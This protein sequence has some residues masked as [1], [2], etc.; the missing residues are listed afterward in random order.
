MRSN[1]GLQIDNPSRAATPN[2]TTVRQRRP[3]VDLLNI[4]LEDLGR[5]VRDDAEDP[6]VSHVMRYGQ[7]LMELGLGSKQKPKN[8]RMIYHATLLMDWAAQ[9]GYTLTHALERMIG[10]AHSETWL[11]GSGHSE[12]YSLE[13]A[14]ELYENVLLDLDQAADPSVWLEYSQVLLFQGNYDLGSRTT[15]LIATKFADSPN[16]PIYLLNAAAMYFAAGSFDQA[17]KNLFQSIQQGPPKFFTKSEMLFMLSRTFEQS[18]TLDDSRAEDGYFMVFQNLDTV[19][20]GGDLT[21]EE[22]LNSASTWTQIADKCVMYG[23]YSLASDLYGQALV[24]DVSAFRNSKIWFRYSK[25]S[26]R[27][28]KSSDA[29]LSV[30]QAIALDPDNAICQKTLVAWSTITEAIKGLVS[31]PFKDVLAAIAETAPLR[32]K[33]AAANEKESTAKQAARMQ[34]FY[35]G[36]VNRLVPPDAPLEDR[37]DIAEG[38]SARAAIVARLVLDHGRRFMHHHMLLVARL[39]FASES[40][41][42]VKIYD[43]KTTRTVIVKLKSPFIVPFVEYR[44]TQGVGDDVSVDGNNLEVVLSHDNAPSVALNRLST[45]LTGEQVSTASGLPSKNGV[46]QH[47]S[48][49]LRRIEQFYLTVRCEHVASRQLEAGSR[50]SSPESQQSGAVRDVVLVHLKFVHRKSGKFSMRQIS[51]NFDD[52]GGLAVGEAKKDIFGDS[53]VKRRA[54]SPEYDR[55]PRHVT[56]T[57]PAKE[58]MATD[59]LHTPNLLSPVLEERLPRSNSPESRMVVALDHPAESPVAGPLAERFEDSKSQMTDS[60]GDF[61]SQSEEPSLK[62]AHDDNASYASSG[63]GYSSSSSYTYTTGSYSYDESTSQSAYTEIDDTAVPRGTFRFFDMLY[64]FRAYHPG[65]EAALDVSY[66][67]GTRRLANSRGQHPKAVQAGLKTMA[68]SM[69]IHVLQVPT[70]KLFIFVL[71]PEEMPHKRLIYQMVY[72]LLS[73]AREMSEAQHEFDPALETVGLPRDDGN[74]QE[75]EVHKTKSGDIS[76]SKTWNVSGKFN[77]SLAPPSSH[78]RS[79]SSRAASR[80]AQTVRQRT[81]RGVKVLGRHLLVSSHSP[82]PGVVRIY[83][84]D[85]LMR[86]IIPPRM[87]TADDDEM[88][89]FSRDSKSIDASRV[90]G[91]SKNSRSIISNWDDGNELTDDEADLV[92]PS[93]AMAFTK[94]DSNRGSWNRTPSVDDRESPTP[95]GTPLVQPSRDLTASSYDDGSTASSYIY[96]DDQSSHGSYSS[97]SYTDSQGLS[98]S[99][100]TYT[101][102]SASM[103]YSSYSDGS[104]SYTQ[105]QTTATPSASKSY[106]ESMSSSILSPSVQETKQSTARAGPGVISNTAYHVDGEP[107][108]L[109]FVEDS[110]D[111]DSSIVSDPSYDDGERES[112]IVRTNSN[113]LSVTSLVNEVIPEGDEDESRPLTDTETG[114]ETGT[115]ESRMV[116]PGVYRVVYGDSDSSTG[117]GGGTI[118]S[119]AGRGSLSSVVEESYGD[120]DASAASS[121]SYFSHEIMPDDDSSSKFVNV[122]GTGSDDESLG[123]TSQWT[124]STHE[125]QSSSAQPEPSRSLRG[126]SVTS[127]DSLTLASESYDVSSYPEGSST[128]GSSYI[129]ASTSYVTGGDSQMDLSSSYLDGSQTSYVTGTTSSYSTGPTGSSYPESTPTASRA[130]D[131]MGGSQ[132]QDSVAPIE[133]MKAVSQEIKIEPEIEVEITMSAE[134]VLAQTVESRPSVVLD[135]WIAPIPEPE[136][137]VG[138][139][140]TRST[141]TFSLT[142]LPDTEDDSSTIH[143]MEGPETTHHSIMPDSSIYSVADSH[144]APESSTYSE[145]SGFF[146]DSSYDGSVSVLLEDSRTE[147]S[148]VLSLLPEGSRVLSTASVPPELFIEDTMYSQVDGYD[149][150]SEV[151]SNVLDESSLG[152]LDGSIAEYPANSFSWRDAKLAGEVVDA[153]MLQALSAIVAIPRP[154]PKPLAESKPEKRKSKG[155]TT[156]MFGGA[157]FEDIEP[158]APEESQLSIGSGSAFSGYYDD[159]DQSFDF[160]GTSLQEG[161]MEGGLNVMT[162]KRRGSSSSASYMSF[163]EGAESARSKATKA[164]AMNFLAWQRKRLEAID[165]ISERVSSAVRIVTRR[166][167]F[168]YLKRRA[169]QAHEKLMALSAEHM[170]K[171]SSPS[172][173]EDEASVD[174]ASSRVSRRGRRSRG[175]SRNAVRFGDAPVTPLDGSPITERKKP[176]MRRASTLSAS[177]LPKLSVSPHLSMLRPK[178]L[179]DDKTSESARAAEEARVKAEADRRAKAYEEEKLRLL[180]E[181]EKRLSKMSPLDALNDP[182]MLL[183]VLKR[184]SQ[185]M[186]LSWTGQLESVEKSD[187]KK[188]VQWED[189]LA[190]GQFGGGPAKGKPKR[191]HHKTKQR[192]IKMHN[193]SPVDFLD[194]PADD[195]AIVFDKS[196][197][198][199]GRVG[200]SAGSCEYLQVW[201]SKIKKALDNFRT[202]SQLNR[203]V[204]M[205][206]RNVGKDFSTELSRAEALVG[207]AEAGGSPAEALGVLRDTLFREEALNVCRS[208]PLTEVEKVLADAC[209]HGAAAFGEGFNQS[210]M[211]TNS[212]RKVGMSTTEAVDRAKNKKL[213]DAELCEMFRAV[214]HKILDSGL[215][216]EVIHHIASLQGEQDPSASF[217]ASSSFVA[218]A[219]EPAEPVSAAWKRKSPLE[220]LSPDMSTS[221][222]ETRTGESAMLPD[223]FTS[224]QLQEQ[225][226]QIPRNASRTFANSSAIH[227]RQGSE[228]VSVASSASGSTAST[229]YRNEVAAMSQSMNLQLQQQPDGSVHLANNTTGMTNTTCFAKKQDHSNQP[230][231]AIRV[232]RTIEM[233][234][235]KPSSAE[236]SMKTNVNEDIMSARDMYKNRQKQLLSLSPSYGVFKK[237]AEMSHAKF[238]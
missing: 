224:P 185:S 6:D 104:S 209:K 3:P 79:G 166:D 54:D 178:A 110:A 60:Q 88:T 111:S 192:R 117:L 97:N 84:A 44:E 15:A 167:A 234:M 28:G 75:W 152:S 171:P 47:L 46:S 193:K 26:Y 213:R 87:R 78:S 154:L 135:E 201:N 168:N 116:A 162:P 71:P 45:P 146:P 145:V 211:F 113:S 21:Y 105:G 190:S 89:E 43:I 222:Y 191:M 55:I 41:R 203:A 225:H 218:P 151:Y 223:I 94:T 157:N 31:G 16:A 73:V 124:A 197:A 2:L 177:M 163:T 76:E 235:K 118:G 53:R 181:E 217:F 236:S 212:G 119:R 198:D 195:S 65:E 27:C 18:G 199:F 37:V 165:Y 237:Q 233:M 22:W 184:Q 17:G 186:P 48:D 57:P 143:S 139:P 102:T 85:P 214:A 170:P 172:L 108:E 24:R 194:D 82:H 182:A 204:E 1:S 80:R 196:I 91:R 68:Q 229:R 39:H 10:Y 138:S 7:M 161:S 8:P 164:Q 150:D 86:S 49:S 158:I 123:S 230:P 30:K 66:E 23:L 175:A 206:R 120:D 72:F 69:A 70:N 50:P 232:G 62:D 238:K 42:S 106:S 142:I 61:A 210:T 180:R 35:R 200:Y 129:S 58:Q 4:T 14:K 126:N 221:H 100:S 228:D 137:T 160:G 115:S 93:P 34:V 202:V 90:S 144:F 122:D 81:M 101:A 153:A 173:S 188:G 20:L 25:S 140:E 207:L 74:V 95:G 112:N 159:G 130:E 208:M 98:A 220:I 215:S 148:D 187:K 12:T 67:I 99:G 59:R 155:Q 219:P 133:E 56:A 132:D 40:V 64:M 149:Y 19:E 147:Y 109:T 107:S 96:Q 9:H 227:S 231:G 33:S 189:G 103:S 29:Q 179:D 114:T 205:L 226:Q 36:E 134:P 51:L 128:V 169:A 183:K 13:R 121:V 32:P 125:S 38:M 83:I 156:S 174:S 52:E 176:P 77:P 92:P 11:S 127:Y 63:S 131:F 5:I 216:S 136:E 141:A